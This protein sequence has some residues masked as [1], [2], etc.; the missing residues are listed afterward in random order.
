MPKPA[1]TIDPFDPANYN[2]PIGGH[3]HSSAKHPNSWH[4][5]IRKWGKRAKVHRL[6]LGQAAQSYR[7]TQVKMILKQG[8]I[9]RTA[10]HKKFDSLNEFVSALQEFEP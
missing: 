8:V 7:W 1:A 3:V 9:G 10:H 2:S 5:D 6:L 4:H